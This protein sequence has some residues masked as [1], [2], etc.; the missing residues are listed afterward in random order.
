MKYFPEY[1]PW[2]EQVVNTQLYTTPFACL[3][4]L[5]PGVYVVYDIKTQKSYCFNVPQDSDCDYMKILNI[6]EN[7]DGFETLQ[8]TYNLIEY[9]TP[10]DKLTEKEMYRRGYVNRPII[11]LCG[12]SKFKQ[13]FHEIEAK[14]CLEGNI[15]LSMNLFGHADNLDVFKPKTKSMLDDIH[16]QKIIMSDKIFVINVGGYIGESTKSEIEFAKRYNIAVEYLED[17][18]SSRKDENVD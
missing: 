2:S 9:G 12:S 5:G 10:S 11:T 13:T 7:P 8:K 3:I 14:L 4:V 17:P 6:L 15:V 1:V 16:R 18:E